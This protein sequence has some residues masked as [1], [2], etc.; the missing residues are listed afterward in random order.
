MASRIVIVDMDKIDPNPYR[1]LSTYPYKEK[2]VERLVRSISDTFFWEGVLGRQVGDRTQIAFGHHRVEAAR[3]AGKRTVPIIIHDDFDDEMMLKLVGRE[4]GEEYSAD[5]LAL[6]NTWEAALRFC[7]QARDAAAPRRSR[8]IDIARLLG[9][10]DTDK[11]GDDRMNKTAR[12]C[13]AALILIEEGRL[14]REAL[15]GLSVKAARGA[16][17][18]V[19][20]IEE[21]ER[22][23][24]ED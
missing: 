11:V 22:A 18:Y 17:R 13:N 2:T 4:N 3:R 19:T 7:S 9:W 21:I 20:R 24:E 5:F 15:A 1:D 16:V 8:S 12:A 6:L 10:F 14:N 23:N